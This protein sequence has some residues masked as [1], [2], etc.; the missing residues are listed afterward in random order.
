MPDEKPR[1]TSAV[2]ATRDDI[3]EEFA[4]LR[5]H[6]DLV[7]EDLRREIHFLIEHIERSLKP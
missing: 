6:A 4:Q 1:L 3:R 2:L 5:R 7:F